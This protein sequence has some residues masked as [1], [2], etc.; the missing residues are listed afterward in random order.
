LFFFLSSSLTLQRNAESF[1]NSLKTL[2]TQLE[3]LLWISKGDNFLLGFLSLFIEEKTS[4]YLS[5]EVS[6]D[7]I[8]SS[9]FFSSNWS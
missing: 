3:C 6:N 1:R 9:I 7:L 8:V 2:F 5:D 4:Y